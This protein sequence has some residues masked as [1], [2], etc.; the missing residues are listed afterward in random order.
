[1]TTVYVLTV[2]HIGTDAYYML[3]EAEGLPRPSVLVG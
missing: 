2:V 1:M 3:C